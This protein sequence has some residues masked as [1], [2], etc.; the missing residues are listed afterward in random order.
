[1]VRSVNTFTKQKLSDIESLN[2]S[3]EKIQ[4]NTA[5]SNCM[6][7]FQRQEEL[8][9]DPECVEASQDCRSELNQIEYKM[10]DQWTEALMVISSSFIVW[11]EIRT[12]PSVTPCD[13]GPG[14]DDNDNVGT[15]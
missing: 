8:N 4:V 5:M 1:M 11:P 10:A 2:I 7:E 15:T 12:S 6:S 13:K 14:R 9:L 3:G